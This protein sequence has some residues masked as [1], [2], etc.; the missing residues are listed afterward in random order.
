MSISKKLKSN[1]LKDFSSLFL[2]N[3]FQ[4][5]LGLIREMIIAFFF[6]TSVF[7]SNFLVVQSVSGV[8]SLF[9][10]HNSLKA[11]FLPKFTKVFK[12]YKEISLKK[13]F[14]FSKRV[15]VLLFISSQ[16]IQFLAIWFLDFENTES[17]LLISI[18]LSFTICLNFNNVLYLTILQAEGKFIKYS[19]ASTLNEFVVTVFIYP[20]SWF[21]NVIG[22]AFVR[23]LGT[24]SI[25]YTYVLPMNKR[26]SGFELELSNKDFNFP[27]LILGNFASLIILTSRFVSGIDGGKE[28]AYFTY[29][30]F[31]LNALLTTIIA[32]IS[33]LLLRQV[34]MN[35]NTLFMVYSLII[36]IL[37]G[38]LSVFGLN[39]FS[40]E[41]IELIF[42][43]GEF[44][45]EDVRNT[46]NFINSLSYSF[47]LIFISTTLF[48]P[49]FSLSIE[50][51][52]I[53][54]RNISLIFV[55]TLLIG[56]TF[57]LFLEFSAE[58]ESLIMIYS[59]SI[60]SLFLSIYSY[61]YYLKHCK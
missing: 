37:V 27:T 17:L 10:T 25:L 1:T 29:S 8:F 5:F 28:I 20:L 60:I 51:T 7:Y 15:M 32:N 4:K 61:M 26:E 11:N 35:K 14:S 55:S 44:D 23:V 22:F 53:V 49:F 3:V 13:I 21:L 54:R 52:K 33:T 19:L 57:S 6:G 18:L 38:I 39:Y 46:S 24:L 50:S 36:S 48:Q 45:I 59:A 40:F 42:M 31:I 2:S 30:V 12:Q 56:L 9:T 47:V 16:F 43:R 58:L 34:S 41:L